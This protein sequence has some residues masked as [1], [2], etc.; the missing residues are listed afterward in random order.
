MRT[1][2]ARLIF[3]CGGCDDEK[4]NEKQTVAVRGGRGGG[5]RLED[6]ARILYKSRPARCA[7]ERTTIIIIIII[8]RVRR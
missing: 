3:H 8:A 1:A 7:H 6:F 4:T 5:V 2:A